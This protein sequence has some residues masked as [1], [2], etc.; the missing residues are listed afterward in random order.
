MI[1]LDTCLGEFSASLTNSET[2]SFILSQTGTTRFPFAAWYLSR[3]Q[4]MPQQ[5]TRTATFDTLQIWK[6]KLPLAHQKTSRH[7]DI[8]PL[9]VAVLFISVTELSRESTT[10]TQACSTDISIHLKSGSTRHTWFPWSRFG[11][12]HHS[13]K[14]QYLP[15]T[16]HKQVQG[17]QGTQ[18]S[19]SGPWQ[20]Y[21]T[22]LGT[23]ANSNLPPLPYPVALDRIHLFTILFFQFLHL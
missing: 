6:S 7:L 17:P 18:Q 16:Y 22:Y 2:S 5:S 11:R 21:L 10:N 20:L 12:P 9:M 23:N 3:L 8:L 4:C 1:G 15:D 19:Y 14:Q 13:P